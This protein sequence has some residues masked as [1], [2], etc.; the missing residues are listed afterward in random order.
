MLL[1][2]K[3]Y[4]S[5]DDTPKPSN[6]SF[7]GGANCPDSPTLHA[8]V[9]LRALYPLRLNEGVPCIHATLPLLDENYLISSRV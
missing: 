6:P 2:R 5:G 9:C 8:N 1:V 7:H 4:S 3:V